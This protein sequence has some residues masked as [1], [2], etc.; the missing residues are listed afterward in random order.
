MSRPDLTRPVEP[1]LHPGEGQVDGG[2]SEGKALVGLSW[3]KQPVACEKGAKE[4]W[5]RVS[6]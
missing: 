5:E 6:I 4:L 2:V 1:S 3:T